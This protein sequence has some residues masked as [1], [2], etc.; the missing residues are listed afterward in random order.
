MYRRIVLLSVLLFAI[1]CPQSAPIPRA[2]PVATIT[3][4]N[5]CAL[6]DIAAVSFEGSDGARLLWRV[7]PN[8]EQ[9]RFFELRGG[10]L[11]YIPKQ[12]G[13]TNVI[14]VAVRNND[15]A[16]ATHE[17]IVS[18]GPRPD[19]NP[20]P[21]PDPGPDPNPQ[22]NPTTELKALA[23][24]LANQHITTNR[25]ADGKLLGAAIDS[26]CQNAAQYSTPQEFREAIRVACHAA[27]DIRVFDWQPVSN[28][29][30][31]AIGNLVQQ[32]KIKTTQDYANAYAEVAAGF[33]T[34]Q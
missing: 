20:D 27:L 1:G 26:V 28:G 12:Q 8:D 5:Y 34:L 9:R 3:G 29:I 30:A 17:I 18:S 4:D 19:P 10:G 13:V 11:L 14:L 6:G 21:N 2:E 24:K 16:M 22:P 23:Q 25:V 15:V 33:Q 32:G 7:L 31:N